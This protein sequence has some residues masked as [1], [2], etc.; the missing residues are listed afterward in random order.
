MS[1]AQCNRLWT[2]TEREQEAK[3][4]LAIV[5]FPVASRMKV[6]IPGLD[7]FTKIPRPFFRPQKHSNSSSIALYICWN[8]V[9]LKKQ[10]TA[11][12]HSVIEGPDMFIKPRLAQRPNSSEC[13]Q[14]GHMSPRIRT[15]HLYLAFWREYF[16]VF[17][18]TGQGSDRHTTA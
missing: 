14:H 16:H 18:L 5:G 3:E 6:A 1:G 8:T 12:H 9:S 10:T 7:H 17:A 2:H 11:E 13:A 4:P 15:R